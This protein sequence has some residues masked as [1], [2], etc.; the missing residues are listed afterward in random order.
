MHCHMFWPERRKFTILGVGELCIENKILRHTFNLC[1]CNRNFY[2]YQDVN[3]YNFSGGNYLPDRAP[4]ADDLH[5]ADHPHVLP[6]LRHHQ[7][8]QD[9]QHPDQAQDEVGGAAISCVNASVV[10]CRHEIRMSVVMMT[11]V[12]VFV[13][14]NVPRMLGMLHEVSCIPDIL[15]CY[16]RGCQYHV[17][18]LRC[19]TNTN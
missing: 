16:D 15:D 12:T 9:R 4:A 7:P 3:Q 18:S 14:T 6:Q 5:L 13:V 19:H 8:L 10:C 11:L 17:T 1:N 2:S